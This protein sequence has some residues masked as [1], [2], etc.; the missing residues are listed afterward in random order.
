[1]GTLRKLSRIIEDLKD[2][3][4]ETEDVMVD[5]KAVHIIVSDEDEE[6]EPNPEVE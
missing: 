3:G 4:V 2:K 5:P 6:G 1:M